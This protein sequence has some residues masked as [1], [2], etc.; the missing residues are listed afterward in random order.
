MLAWFPLVD[1]NLAKKWVPTNYFAWGGKTLCLGQLM[2]QERAG[3][4]GGVKG[5][6]VCVCVRT[7]V[8]TRVCTQTPKTYAWNP[9]SRE[10]F[11]AQKLA[12]WL[13]LHPWH[14]II[15]WMEASASL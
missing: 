7:H 9:Q 4:G 10:G 15:C 3:G 8:C 5:D 6:G 11:L 14:L 13:T 12:V 1:C 2:C